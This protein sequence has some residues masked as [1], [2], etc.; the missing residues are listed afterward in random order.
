[1]DAIPE[2]KIPVRSDFCS[3]SSSADGWRGRLSPISA[4]IVIVVFMANY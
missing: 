1:V 4:R 3:N 2:V